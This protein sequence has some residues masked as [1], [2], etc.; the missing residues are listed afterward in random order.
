LRRS[1][2]LGELPNG[3]RLSSEVETID[4]RVIKQAKDGNHMIRDVSD[5][6]PL[7]VIKVSICIRRRD[8]NKV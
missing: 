6:A 1:V 8:P 4:L 2:I 7:F 3:D 5:N